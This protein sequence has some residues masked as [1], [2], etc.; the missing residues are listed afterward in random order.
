MSGQPKSELMILYPAVSFLEKKYLSFSKERI[1][2]RKSIDDPSNA[3]S[4]CFRVVSSVETFS[5]KMIQ[6]LK[7]NKTCEKNNQ[8]Q[9]SSPVAIGITWMVPH[10]ILLWLP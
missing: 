6:K 7:A 10:K 1:R 9:F 5:T 8:L 2:A 3:G 4:Y